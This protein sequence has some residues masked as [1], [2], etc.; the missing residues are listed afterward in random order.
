MS[1]TV[2][3]A[4]GLDSSL[5][6]NHGLV[7]R[8]AGYFFT[9]TYSVREAILQFKDGDFDLILVGYAIPAE[10]REKLTSVIRASGSRIPVVSITNGSG[11][12]DTF[13]DATIRNE[14]NDVIA[15]IEVLLA[16]QAMTPA[17]PASMQGNSR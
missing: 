2:V 16:R 5:L 3:L 13:A 8:T 9:S 1:Q 11:H 17:A 14:P 10:S 4:V 12:H 6:A 7:S 15:A